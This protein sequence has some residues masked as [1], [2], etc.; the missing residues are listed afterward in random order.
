M[1]YLTDRKRAAGLGSAKSG[2]AHFWAMKV[3]SVALLI[4]VPLFVFTFGPVLGQ[5]FDVVLDYYSRPF[6]AIVAA[7]TLAVGFK[8]FA[9]GA[10]VMLEDYVHGTLEKVLIILVTCLSYGAAAAGIFAIARI[11]L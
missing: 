7:L 5:P 8:H 11:A 1:R 9:D 4:L 10:Q 3:S 2:T 6:P